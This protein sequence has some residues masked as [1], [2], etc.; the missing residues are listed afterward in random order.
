MARIAGASIETPHHVIDAKESASAL[1]TLLPSR[2]ASRLPRLIEESRIKTRHLAA[3][4]TE[5][6]RL[7]T[8]DERQAKFVEHAV[9]L[10]TSVARRALDEAGL[11]PGDVSA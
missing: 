10:G 11:E 7:R 2:A 4:L 8:M 1:A 9:P 3:P 5:L 6:A